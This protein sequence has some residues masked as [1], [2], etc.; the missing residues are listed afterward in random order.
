[1]MTVPAG[2]AIRDWAEVVDAAVSASAKPH[3]ATRGFL[4]GTIC[5]V[6]PDELPDPQAL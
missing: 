4:S 6:P 1:M 3:A 2:S 5:M